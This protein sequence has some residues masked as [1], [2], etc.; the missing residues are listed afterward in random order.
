MKS[1]SGDGTLK[2]YQTEIRYMIWE[3]VQNREKKIKREGDFGDGEFR[4]IIQISRM[5]F[6]N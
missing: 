2:M 3:S 5:I 4:E 6:Q 1:A